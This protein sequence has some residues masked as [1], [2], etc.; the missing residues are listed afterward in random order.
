[1][2]LWKIKYTRRAR[3]VLDKLDRV[4]KERIEKYIDELCEKPNPR[5]KGKG[6]TGSRAGQWRYRVGDYRII[7][8]IQDG[9]FIVLVLEIGH[10]SDVYK[11]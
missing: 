9:F 11:K 1:M 2:T 8:E 4:A 5:I 6:L 3:K 10:R 7:C